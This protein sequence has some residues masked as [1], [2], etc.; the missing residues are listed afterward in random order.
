MSLIKRCQKNTLVYWPLESFAST[1][2]PIFGAPDEMKCR[3][4]DCVRQI[5]GPNN[6]RVL[7]SVEVITE[8]KLAVGGLIKLGT[9][10]SIT[11]WDDPK[12]NTGCYEILKVC[13]TPNLKNRESL[14][15]AYA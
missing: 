12:Q 5:I 4:D 10:D 15:E 3:W 13:E 1:G 2:E 9:L 11:H 8:F 6:T 7:S 14:Y